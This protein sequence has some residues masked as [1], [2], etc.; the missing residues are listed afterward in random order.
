LKRIDSLAFV[1][2]AVRLLLPSTLVFLA[3]DAHPDPTH[4]SL[5]DADSCPAFDRWR[6]LRANGVAVDFR[7]IV[8]AGPLKPCPLDLTE[9]EE[10]SVIGTSRLY[11]RRSDRSLIIV[12]SIPLSESIEDWQVATEI[13]NL[14]NLRHP[15]IASPIGF[16]GSIGRRELKIGRSYARGGSLAEVLSNPPPW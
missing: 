7:R 1:G 14:A 16:E 6:R 11:Q 2:C 10:G 3:H 15:L 8:S 13:E 5:S 4:L 12:R 9:Y